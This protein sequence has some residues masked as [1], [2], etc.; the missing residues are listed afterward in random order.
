MIWRHHLKTQYL[1]FG[2]AK[3]RIMRVGLASIFNELI[4]E[5]IY[6]VKKL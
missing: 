1:N 3:G 5:I 6:N 2:F 4:A